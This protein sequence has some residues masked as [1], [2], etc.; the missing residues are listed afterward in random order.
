MGHLKSIVS[1]VDAALQAGELVKSLI[2]WILIFILLWGMATQISNAENP[3]TV[4]YEQPTVQWAMA[5]M[6]VDF[7]GS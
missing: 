2:E 4:P 6:S 7:N 3:E 5:N 1:R